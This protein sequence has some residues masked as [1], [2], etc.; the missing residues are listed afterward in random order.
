MGSWNVLS[1]TMDKGLELVKV[2][3][4]YS[5]NLLDQ[6]Q[7]NWHRGSFPKKTLLFRFDGELLRIVTE[8][9]EI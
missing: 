7:G 1:L 8:D 6:D 9:F 4:E 5:G 2:S 3:S